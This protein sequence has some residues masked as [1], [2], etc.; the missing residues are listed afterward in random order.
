MAKSDT[1]VEEAVVVRNIFW[2]LVNKKNSSLWS[3]QDVGFISPSLYIKSKFSQIPAIFLVLNKS[4]QEENEALKTFRW[5]LRHK[6][7]L[8]SSQCLWNW[9]RVHTICKVFWILSGDVPINTIQTGRCWWMCAKLWYIQ[10]TPKPQLQ[11]LPWVT[12]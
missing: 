8:N 6:A 12:L 9:K 1:L 3:C 4:H 5:V 7:C 10:G 11:V 2:Q